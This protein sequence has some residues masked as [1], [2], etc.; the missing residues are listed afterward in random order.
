VELVAGLLRGMTA[1]DIL[2]RFRRD[3]TATGVDDHADTIREV[4]R[5]I[6]SAP[7]LRPL[8]S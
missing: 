4:Y 7:A 3:Q 8:F 1:D 5:T 2:D 6:T